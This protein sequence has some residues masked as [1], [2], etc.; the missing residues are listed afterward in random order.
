MQ[1]HEFNQALENEVPTGNMIPNPEHVGINATI[2]DIP[3]AIRKGMR[4]CTHT[5][6]R[7]L[8]P[9]ENCHQV[10]GPL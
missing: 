8:S 10:T 6:L 2:S 3:I 4:A 9:M 1:N 5:L 7:D